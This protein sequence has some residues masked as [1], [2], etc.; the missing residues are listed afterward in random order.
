M[1]AR[2]VAV[3]DAYEVMTSPRASW[4]GTVTF[5]YQVCAVDG[6]CSTGSVD[7]TVVRDGPQQGTVPLPLPLV[8]GGA[9]LGTVIR[10]RRT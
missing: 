4:S 3:P 5:T 1:G 6:A 7:V 2:I 10:H 9:A 8:M